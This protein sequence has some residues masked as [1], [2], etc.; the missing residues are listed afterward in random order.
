MF[1]ATG[2][3]LSIGDQSTV[4]EIAANTLLEIRNSTPPMSFRFRRGDDPELVRSL[5]K[6]QKVAIALE[7]R[8]KDGNNVYLHDYLS[9]ELGYEQED[10]FRYPLI[11]EVVGF[12]YDKDGVTKIAPVIKIEGFDPIIFRNNN[13]LEPCG[14]LYDQKGIHAL[15]IPSIEERKRKEIKRRKGSTSREI[16]RDGLNEV[17]AALDTNIDRNKGALDILVEGLKNSIGNSIEHAATQLQ[18]RLNMG[19]MDPLTPFLRDRSDSLTFLKTNARSRQVFAYLDG[20]GHKRVLE[21]LETEREYPLIAGK[22]LIGVREVNITNA[23]NG[24]K[25]SFGEKFYVQNDLYRGVYFDSRYAFL[26]QLEE[27]AK[28][29]YERDFK[30]GTAFI[31][32]VRYLLLEE[33]K[34]N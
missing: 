5:E 34:N 26:D 30:L 4:R 32:A 10:E 2:S 28:R 29:N 33:D 20:T 9:I 17:Q 11:G 8:V 27:L 31:L 16:L 14:V 24:F 18:G 12:E 21:I 22:G 7:L 25:L 1:N 23:D 19:E 13:H 6:G 15:S 3:E